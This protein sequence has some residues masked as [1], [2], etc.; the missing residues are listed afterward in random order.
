MSTQDNKALVERY[1]GL[2]N[3]ANPQQMITDLSDDFSFESMLQKPEAFHVTWDRETFANVT[4]GMATQ[5]LKPLKVSIISM[6]A[7]DDKVAV[8]ATS[9]GE[10]NNG[11]TYANAYHFLFKVRDRKIYNIREYSCSYTAYDCLGDFF[12]AAPS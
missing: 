12:V 1:I 6:M 5:M 9:Y 8:E 2:M 11:K 10:M 7:E 4:A 3:Q